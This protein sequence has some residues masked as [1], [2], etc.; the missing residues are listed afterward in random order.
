MEKRIIRYLK[1]S[2]LTT[3]LGYLIKSFI[4]WDILW[5]SDIGDWEQEERIVIILAWMLI[6]C[7]NVFISLS[8]FLKDNS[9]PKD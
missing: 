1:I 7:I 6:H 5:I 9:L 8:D 3:I 4:S 2:S